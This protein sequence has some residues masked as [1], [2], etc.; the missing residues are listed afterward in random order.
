MH[1]QSISL[2]PTRVPVLGVSPVVQ[3]PGYKCYSG[4]AL[5]VQS[6]T[7]CLNVS[8]G[9]CYRWTAYKDAVEDAVSLYQVGCSSLSTCRCYHPLQTLSAHRACTTV[10]VIGGWCFRLLSCLCL[11]L[12]CWGNAHAMW[13]CLAWAWSCGSVSVRMIFFKLRYI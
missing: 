5:V 7:T 12:F 9:F 13:R 1:N 2:W 4:S 6:S 10:L 3:C 11:R 8:R